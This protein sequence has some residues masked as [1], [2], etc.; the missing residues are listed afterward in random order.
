[1]ISNQTFTTITIL[2]AIYLLPGGFSFHLYEK[3][4]VVALKANKNGLATLELDFGDSTS[5]VTVDTEFVAVTSSSLY[6]LRGWYVFYMEIKHLYTKP[7]KY[8]VKVTGH[9]SGGSSYS[10]NQVESYLDVLVSDRR[11]SRPFVQYSFTSSS[12]NEENNNNGDGN[13][14]NTPDLITIHNSLPVTIPASAFSACPQ[15]NEMSFTWD[16]Y[17]V[18]ASDFKTNYMGVEKKNPA[19]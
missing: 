4:L 14:I 7:G 12:S 10:L 18:E 1:M 3:K 13:N 15:S 11:C 19:P 2:P 9:G 17:T 16:L 8:R 6:I 5:P